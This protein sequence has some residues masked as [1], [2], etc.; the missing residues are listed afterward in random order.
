MR[1][2]QRHIDIVVNEFGLKDAKPVST[3]V[4]KEDVERMLQDLGAPLDPTQSTQHRAMAAR[5]D[6]LALDRP[7]VQF[8]TK[9]ASK[10]MANLTG[11]DLLLMKRP[12]RHLKGNPRLVQTF[13]WQRVQPELCTYTL[14]AIGL[15]TRPPASRPAEALRS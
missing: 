7:D 14:I 5:P 3:L 4:S 12:A 10:Y 1:F 9:E 15:A 8:V 11:C 6:Y 2:D 13:R